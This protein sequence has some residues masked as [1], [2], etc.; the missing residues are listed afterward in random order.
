[1]SLLS[2]P[3]PLERYC[4]LLP[5]LIGGILLSSYATTVIAGDKIYSW[6]DA[7]G[8]THFS[9]QP[10]AEQGEVVTLSTQQL[11]PAKIGTVTPKR[12]STTQA[13]AATYSALS[14]QTQADKQQAELICKNA[15]HSL[16]MLNTHPRLAHKD[17]QTGHQ[18]IL[19]DAQRQEAIKQAKSR[20]AQFCQPQ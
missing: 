10:P 14:K 9:Q 18:I 19:S 4:R 2:Y 12:Y 1:M 20:I 3:M 8:V 15:R 5:L 11:S 17:P 6:T 16:S 13:D 7:Q